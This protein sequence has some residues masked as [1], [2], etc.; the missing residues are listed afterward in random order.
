MKEAERSQ[1]KNNHMDHS[2]VPF[3]LQDSVI[4]YL[5]IACS[6]KQQPCQE[7]AVTI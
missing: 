5:V 3:K 2:E 4:I 7:P 1:S 6:V